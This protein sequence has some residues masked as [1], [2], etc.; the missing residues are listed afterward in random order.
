M[1]NTDFV[2]SNNYTIYNNNSSDIAIE[3]SNLTKHFEN[4]KAIDNLSLTVRYGEIF[5]LT[6]KQNY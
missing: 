4:V 5:G 6:T 2:K 3:I 1:K